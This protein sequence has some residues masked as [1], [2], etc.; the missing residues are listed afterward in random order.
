[1]GHHRIAAA[2]ALLSLLGC[3]S[4]GSVSPLLT[5]E[6]AEEE[7]LL[8]GTWQDSSGSINLFI[9]ADGHASYSLYLTHYRG[10]SREYRAT[11]GRIGAVR[12][13][14]LQAT[15]PELA[16]GIA[17]SGLTVELYLPVLVE[18][19]SANDMTLGDLSGGA[20][21]SYLHHKPKAIAHVSQGDDIIITAPTSA[22][23]RFFQ[24]YVSRPYA[25]RKM[26]FLRR[27]TP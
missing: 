27:P 2:L 20:L 22:W 12:V 24:K 25:I 16:E 10:D 15:D 11:L 18:T 14:E 1:M 6:D 21:G 8:R 5:A 7:P 19:I 9:P 3:S 26:T 4:V 13:L 23:R 17:A